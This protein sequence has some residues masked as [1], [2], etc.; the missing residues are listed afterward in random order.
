M[1]NYIKVIFVFPLFFSLFSLNIFETNTSILQATTMSST[2]EQKIHETV[3]KVTASA[4]QEI[5]KLKAELDDLRTKSKP[6]IK[7]AET[8]LTSP[9]AIGFYQGG[10]L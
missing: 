10:Y 3:D 9:S 6:K 2:N 5:D 8:F 4:Q 1:H 7:E